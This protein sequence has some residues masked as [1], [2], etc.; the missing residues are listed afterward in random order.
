MFTKD[1]N[2]VD[3]CFQKQY[4]NGFNVG[5]SLVKKTSPDRWEL[6]KEVLHAMILEQPKDV[7]YHA[8]LAGFCYEIE[9]VRSKERHDQRLKEI[10]KINEKVQNREQ[11]HSR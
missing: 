8:T 10:Q 3:T 11:E 9:N 5:L 4:C 6:T 1:R 2:L 7:S